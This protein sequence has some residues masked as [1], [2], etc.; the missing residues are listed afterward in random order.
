MKT[1][2]SVIHRAEFRTGALLA[3]LTSSPTAPSLAQELFLLRMEAP[4]GRV[5][6]YHTQTKSWLP[7][8]PTD[9]NLPSIVMSDSTT[10]TITGVEGDARTTTIVVV[11]DRVD[12]PDLPRGIHLPGNTWKGMTTVSRI[13]NRGRILASEIA[14]KVQEGAGPRAPHAASTFTLPEAPVRVGDTWSATETMPTGPG[15][16]NLWTRILQVTYRLERVDLRGAARVAVISMKGAGTAWLKRVG[17][18][19][20]QQRLEKSLRPG[21]GAI[22]GEIL[23]DL[24]AKWMVGLTVSMEDE[25]GTTRGL[26]THMT[27]TSQ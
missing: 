18:F 10:E 11:S 13:D 21:S 19:P 3:L 26:K 4:I 2:M 7:G 5:M 17:N 6:Q 24:D 12:T 9:S 8:F 22:S 1:S 15:T 23:M 14:Q 16:G 27:K 25:W 20:D